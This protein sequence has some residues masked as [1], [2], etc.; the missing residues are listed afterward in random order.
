MSNV[1]ISGV[2]DG[3]GFAL[4]KLYLDKGSNRLRNIPAVSRATERA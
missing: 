2:S 3:I 1:F 4:A